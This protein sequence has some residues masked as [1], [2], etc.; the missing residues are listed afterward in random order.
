MRRIIQHSD[1]ELEA[2]G[3]YIEDL[4]AYL[5]R[6]SCDIFTDHWSLKYILT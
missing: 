5:Y 6:E 4:E 3:Y 1:L 2:V